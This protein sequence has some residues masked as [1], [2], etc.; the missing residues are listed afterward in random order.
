MFLLDRFFDSL[1]YFPASQQ[2]LDLSATAEFHG[3]HLAV[4]SLVVEICQEELDEVGGGFGVRLQLL[5]AGNDNSELECVKEQQFVRG[6]FL[7]DDDLVLGVHDG[8]QD[9]L[10]VGLVKRAL[11]LLDLLV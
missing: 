9:E 4:V 5:L 2:E 7:L 6:Q 1:V 3:L 11:L 10:L 8:L